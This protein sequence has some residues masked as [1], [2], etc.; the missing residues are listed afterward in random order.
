MSLVGRRMRGAKGA[1]KRSIE[2]AEAGGVWGGVSPSPVGVGFGEG[3]CPFP[4][5]FCKMH[6]EFTH[7]AAS[8]E[9]YNSLRL[10]KFTKLK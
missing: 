3:L 4:R 8:S 2:G 10:S 5:N 6:V 9:D 1:E 7:F